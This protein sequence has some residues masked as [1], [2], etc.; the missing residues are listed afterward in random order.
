ME[1]DVETVR[2][3]IDDFR[4]W[5]QW[6]PW[7]KLDP[8]MTRTYSGAERGVGAAYAWEGDKKAG[9]GHMEISAST[10]TSITVPVTFTAP[11]ESENTSHFDLSP[12]PGGGTDVTWTMTGP[13]STLQKVMFSVLRM[14]AKVAKDFDEGLAALDDATRRALDEAAVGR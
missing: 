4:A 6:S 7:E 1:A 14:N 13:Q 12:S 9:S 10:P 11:F 3:F 2:A 5:K 8:A